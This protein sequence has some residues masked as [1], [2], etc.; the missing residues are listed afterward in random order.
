[1]SVDLAKLVSRTKIS[2]EELNGK[3]IAIDAFNVLYQ[4]LTIIRGPDGTQ[5]KDF[6]GNV[7]S[8]LSGLF[9]RTIELVDNGIRPVYVFDGI[10]SK[11]KQK[12]IE[13]RM[14]RREKAYQAWQKAKEAG[15]MEEA[16]KYAQQSTR[17]NEYII[18]SSKELLNYMGIAHMTAP[19]EGEAQACDMC[20]KGLVYAAASQDYDTLL[21]ASPRI[22]RNLTISGRRK[23][24]KKNVYIEIEPEMVDLKDTL[25]SI[26]VTQKQLIWVGILLGTDFN[27]GIRGVGPVTAVK[28]AKSAKSIADVERYVKEK[29][30]TEF[31]IDIR[32]VEDLFMNPEVN[33]IDAKEFERVLSALPD[34]RKIIEFMCN[35]HDF[36]TERIEKFAE[37]LWEKRASVRQHRLF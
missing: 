36:S 26:G 19:G 4:F 27:E 5:L 9:Y 17:I 7:T 12:T 25:K 16:R 13:A 2:L 15:E 33:D 28:I 35:E 10:P 30:N 24:P 6:K 23:L 22:I 3:T 34:K 14:N 37:K 8:H 29:Y 20:K 18:E 32:E 21:F 31:E 11:L 1:M